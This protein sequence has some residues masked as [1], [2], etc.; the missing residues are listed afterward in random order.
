MNNFIR[1]SDLKCP[2]TDL[3]CAL[4][5]VFKE[6]GSKST[7]PATVTGSYNAATKMLSL[8]VNGASVVINM[9]GLP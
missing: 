4:E 6:Y 2:S 9:A 3:D 8:T 1:I 7:A 5:K